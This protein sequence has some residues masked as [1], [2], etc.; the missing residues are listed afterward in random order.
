VL[1]VE[2]TRFNGR[3]LVTFPPAELEQALTA[4]RRGTPRPGRPPEPL[5]CLPYER[6]PE[7]AF[8][9]LLRIFGIINLLALGGI[10][11]WL[12]AGPRGSAQG[13]RS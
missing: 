3:L 4:A 7:R 1:P 6:D 8:H 5:Y 9:R 13:G 10:L 11:V 2:S 12:L